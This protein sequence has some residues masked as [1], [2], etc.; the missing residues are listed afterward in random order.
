MKSLAWS[1]LLHNK[2][3]SAVAVCGVTFA[4]VLMFMQL[5]FLRAVERTATTIYHA[6]DFDIVLRAPSYLHLSDP[7]SFPMQ[8]VRQA[9]S[10]PGVKQV[11]PFYIRINSWQNPQTLE[12]WGILTMGVRPGTSPYNID[13]LSDQLAQL[14]NQESLLI[15]RKS[16]KKYGPINGVEFGPDDIGQ[17]A[18]ITNKRVKIAGTFE[19]GT[20]LAANAAVV[21]TDSGFIRVTHRRTL[22]EVSLGLVKLADSPTKKKIHDVA[23]RLRETLKNQS[24]VVVLTR[25]EA[26]KK[27]RYYWLFD[28]SIGIIF[29]MGVMVAFLV[30]I[31]IVYQVLATDVA[32]HL[33]EYA[34]LKAI[35]YNNRFL[36]RIVVEQAAILAVAGYLVGFVI[37]LVLFAITSR[38][39]GIPIRMDWRTT[40]LVFVVTFVMCC[41]SGLAALR[42]AY[43][44]E[45]AD[46]F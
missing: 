15:D 23:N 46:L 29:L 13:E 4:V 39:A 2:F 10:L 41:L 22:D 25:A 34:T 32:N 38:G 31:A 27:E 16:K 5:G 14:H 7:R 43:R 37:S 21:L 45:P 6:L 19:L 11:V 12:K 42:K 1:N 33:G 30:G 24:D 20:G 17:V 8:R 44:A 40:S 3:R 26:I 35:G 28:K 9:A 36:A 18:E